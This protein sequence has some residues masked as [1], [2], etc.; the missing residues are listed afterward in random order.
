LPYFVGEFVNQTKNGCH[1][2]YNIGEEDNVEVTQPTH[3]SKISH[4]VKVSDAC[5]VK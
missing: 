5:K 2:E 3:G 4:K 1:G